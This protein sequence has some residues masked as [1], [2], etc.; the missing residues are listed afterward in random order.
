MPPQKKI[1]YKLKELVGERQRYRRIALTVQNTLQISG[2]KSNS[3]THSLTDSY[4]LIRH[5][6]LVKVHNII[7]G[8]S[9]TVIVGKQFN[10]YDSLY[11]YPLESKEL[12]IFVASDLSDKLK[13]WPV[14]EITAKCIVFPCNNKNKSWVSFPIIHTL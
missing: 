3:C 7:K 6:L 8:E 9:D 10:T 2:E 4:C 13:I 11:K 1:K 12:S 14:N 5:T